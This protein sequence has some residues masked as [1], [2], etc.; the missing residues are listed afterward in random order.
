[1]RRSDADAALYWLA[2][3]LEGGEDPLFIARRII[4][5]AS[6]D[7]G[8]ANNSALL[9]AN[10]TFEACHKIGLPECWINLS[11]ATAY[12]AKSPKSNLSYRAYK[13]A[14]QDVWDKGNLD[15]PLH[16]KNAPTKLMKDL[17]YGKDYKYPHSENDNEQNYL[18]KELKGKKYLK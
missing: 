8:L 14:R 7:I 16:L 1:M 3:M 17:G 4:I 6:E 5:F 18:P 10:A 15:V 11:H 9:L 12:M 13:E 2:R